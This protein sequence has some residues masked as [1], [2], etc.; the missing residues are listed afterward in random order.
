MS[1]R[2]EI[3]VYDTIQTGLNSP[4]Y[5][6]LSAHLV[7]GSLIGTGVYK[8]PSLFF[9][10]IPYLPFFSI[11]FFSLS[12]TKI[13][14]IMSPP[15]HQGRGIKKLYIPASGLGI[16]PYICSSCGYWDSLLGWTGL[17]AAGD[18]QRP[19]GSQGEAKYKNNVGSQHHPSTSS[20]LNLTE[21][22]KQLH[23]LVHMLVFLFDIFTPYSFSSDIL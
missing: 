19:P 5:S 7:W 14:S 4:L 12:K 21:H 13:I 10:P 20:K 23:P 22:L 3:L 2:I 16:V 6:Y 9:P 8:V 11:F 15:L 18:S 17:G 1:L